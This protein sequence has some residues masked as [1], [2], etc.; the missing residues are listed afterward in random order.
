MYRVGTGW[1]AHPFGGPGPVILGGAAIDHRQ[2]LEGHSDADVLLHAVCDALFGAAGLPDIGAHFPD[3]D[4]QYKG[5]SS[6]ELLKKT[7]G[8][9]EDAGF[10]VV[11]VDTVIIAQAPR[12]S[13]HLEEMKNNMAAALEIPPRRAGVK[14]SAPEG[15][16][17]IGS[18][19]GIAAQAVACLVKKEI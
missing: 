9:I 15:M 8:I 18:D 3:T 16:G 17:P 11:N 4:Q 2:G 10:R 7:A 5:I 6:I 1:D 12:L 13:D 19:K 14:A